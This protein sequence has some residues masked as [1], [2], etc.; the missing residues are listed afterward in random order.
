M[1]IPGT[2]M[3]RREEHDVERLAE[4]KGTAHLR[5]VSHFKVRREK[6]NALVN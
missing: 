3:E 1:E 5:A 2:K 4:T 6:E